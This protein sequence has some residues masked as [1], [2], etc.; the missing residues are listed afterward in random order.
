MESIGKKLKTAR[1]EKGYSPD[2]V[3]RDTNIARRF[4]V[5]MEEEDFAVFPGDTYLLGFL[6][7]Y[8]DYLGL[9]S[10]KIVNLYRNMKIQEQPLPMEELLQGR[11]KKPPMGLIL[12]AVAVV[13][14]LGGGG[15]GLYTL[16][17]RGGL[18]TESG[19]TEAVDAETSSVDEEGLFEMTEELVARRFPEGQKLA[20]DLGDQTVSFVIEKIGEKVLLET[21]AGQVE[22]G[23]GRSVSLDLTLD[24]RD[25]LVVELQDVDAG[26]RTAVLR[27]DRGI[28]SSG[29]SPASPG[30]QSSESAGREESIGE[31]E[32]LIS[33]GS[34]RAEDRR[35]ESLVIA[36]ADRPEPFRLEV[37]FRGYSLVR[38][39]KDGDIRVE[40]YFNKD[41]TL[42]LDVTREVMLWISNAGSFQAKIAGREVD[43][44]GPGVVAVKL[45][46]WEENKE[47]GRYQLKLLPVY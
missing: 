15:F 11:R 17:N 39:L 3:A 25:D 45:L 19:Q 29:A 34:T 1:E 20:V 18:G 40:K 47:A 14:L 12:I 37:T 31:S 9:D 6:K 21:P 16:L 2:Q 13:L 5:A 43:F 23:L 44:G 4:I 36:E 22:V 7:N 27:L 32:T 41:D 42:R 38:Y 28:G 24:G 30:G 26:G 46:R 35:Q 10:E 8:A 33:T